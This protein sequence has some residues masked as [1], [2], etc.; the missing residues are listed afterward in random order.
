MLKTFAT[1]YFCEFREF[2]ESAK[3]SKFFYHML[4]AHMRLQNF[5]MKL[6]LRDSQKHFVAKVF[7]SRGLSVLLCCY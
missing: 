7:G 4:A 3:V 6:L 1:K 5:F 2:D